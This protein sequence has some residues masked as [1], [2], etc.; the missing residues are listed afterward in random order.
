MIINIFNLQDM[1]LNVSTSVTFLRIV[2]RGHLEVREALTPGQQL[3]VMTCFLK[4]EKG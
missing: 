3:Q 1:G 4:H 2:G